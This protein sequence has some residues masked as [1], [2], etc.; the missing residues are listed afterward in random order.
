MLR[1]DM[2][3]KLTKVPPHPRK[4][5]ESFLSGIMKEEILFNKGSTYLEIMSLV[6]SV[7]SNSLQPHGL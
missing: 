2:K 5:V 6:A 7:V 1:N 3:M 4:P